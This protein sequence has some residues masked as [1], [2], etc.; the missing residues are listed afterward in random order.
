MKFQKLKS[1]TILIAGLLFSLGVYGQELTAKEIVKKAQEK[2][3]GLSSNGIMKMTIVRPDW[4][5]EVEMKT[6]SLGSDFYM[7]YVTAPAR[8]KGQVFLK[9]YNDEISNGLWYK[10][11]DAITR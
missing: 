7:I 6:W 11:K 1:A 5:R 10:R 4:S 3:N 8:D 9:R 2:V